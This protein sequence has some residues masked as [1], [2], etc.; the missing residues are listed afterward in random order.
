LEES[1]PRLTE[2]PS[3]TI[4]FLF[5]DIE[6][7][8][9]LERHL[10][11]RYRDVL[12]EHQRLLREA[13]AR[14]GGREIDTQGDSFFVVFPRARD[15]VAAAVEV[16][17]ALGSQAW[18]DER[19]VRVRIGMHT[20]EASPSDGRYVGLAVHRAA[21]IA[22]AGHGGQILLSGSTR[23]VVEDDLP[24]EQ[25]LSDLG[26]QRLK[27]LPRSERV[28]QLVAPGLA[29]DFPPLKSFEGLAPPWWRKTRVLAPV[30]VVLAAFVAAGALRLGAD[31]EAG[32]AGVSA[33]AL[34]LIDQGSG[35]IDGEVT[36]DAAP[37][38]V[39]RGEGAVWVTNA[40]DGTVSRIDPAGR[41]LRQTIDVGSSPSGIA[42][43]AGAVWVTN[44][45][46]ATVSR[47]DPETDRVVQT[48]AVGNGPLAVAYG[49][50]SV[51][52][53]NSAD[54][55]VSRIE[56]ESGRVVRRI[57]TD[58]VGRGIAVGGGSVWV[59]D[60]SS[61]RVMRLDPQVDEIAEE[62]SVGNGPTGIAFG[63]RA[64]WVANTF[65]GTVSRIDA[66]ESRVTATVAVAGG[67]GAVAVAEGNVW[68]SA[69][70]AGR[71]VRIDA[72]DAKVVD[73]VAIGNRPKGLVVTADGVWVAVQASGRGHRGGRLIVLSAELETIDP[74]LAF[75]PY[76]LPA[77][78]LVHDGLTGF[79]RVGGSEGTQL[80][81]NLAVSI[82]E[83][84]N[85]GRTYTFR[86]RSGLRYGDG[87]PVGPVDFRRALERAFELGSPR[88]KAVVGAARCVKG[89][90]CD[91]SRGVVARGDSITFHL[92]EPSPFFLRD[93]AGLYPIPPGTPRRDVGTKP[94][95]GTGP[96]AIESYVPGRQLRLTR[97]PHFRV[98]SE[99][100][101]PDGNAEEIV[102]SIVRVGDDRVVSD[103]AE[104]RADVALLFP[105]ARTPEVKRRYASQ[106]HLV[107][108][109]ATLYLFLNAKQP[110]FDDPRVRRA[111]NFAIDRRRV[112]ERRGGAAL[113]QPTCQVVPPTTPGYVR[114]CPYTL[115]PRPSG[116]WTAPDLARAR[117]LIA[118]SGTRGQK[119]TVWTIPYFGN[120]ARYVVSLLDR[121][122]YRAEL[123]ELEPLA[124]LEALDDPKLVQSGII[125]EYDVTVAPVALRLLTCDSRDNLARF[126]DREIDRQ[127]QRSLALLETDEG[128]AAQ[129]WA[130]IDRRLV[131]LAPWVPLHT[132]RTPYFVSKRVENWQYHPYFHVLLDQLWVR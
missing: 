80:V 82:P 114:Y 110:P 56:P 21:R 17:R 85:D 61:R 95:S 18:P 78:G 92:S 5:T 108:E 6:G 36:V 90:R 29:S 97:N 22:A 42:V 57:E 101:R 104:G 84:R 77:M 67:P 117:R 69:E 50:G 70:F 99:A 27:D 72:V 94:V 93:V 13:F 24:S 31:G 59:T 102:F 116:E 111:L 3:G 9:R 126:C 122:G 125:G 88:L 75:S 68:V 48:I 43:G 76:S 16:Q 83:P 23:D 10:R 103:V 44:H 46:D 45:D 64:V 87:K 106:L 33:N 127:F 39:A 49:E 34:G 32:A 81:P 25:R 73:A 74:T 52:V 38:G 86:L 124:Y 129:M 11:E 30:A 119:I 58:A 26:E 28:F 2:L 63:R 109:Q 107:S 79:R 113:A 112:V 91:L 98:W 131:D 100:A 66:T 37:T 19:D 20:G 120:E 128:A 12:S 7:S 47:I 89:D 105:T 118:A 65:D 62:I 115:D 121:L 35:N 8:T 1:E 71:L 41:T 53:T 15:A 132:P 130:R 4:T 123:K 55:T 54:R 14:F 40:H 51:W 60:E 96:Y